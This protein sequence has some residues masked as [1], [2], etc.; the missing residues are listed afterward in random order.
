MLFITKIMQNVIHHPVQKTNLFFK[1]NMISPHF[2]HKAI[3]WGREMSNDNFV[4]CNINLPVNFEKNAGKEDAFQRKL[5]T[6]EHTVLTV[7]TRSSTGEHKCMD[8]S[9][10]NLYT[11]NFCVPLCSP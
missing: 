8:I 7:L 10:L 4:K 1:L 3:C 5:Y 9:I 11:S 2:L 6:L